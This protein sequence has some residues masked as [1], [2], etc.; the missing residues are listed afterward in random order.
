MSLRKVA[1]KS[2][3]GIAIGLR[4]AAFMLL[5]CFAGSLCAAAQAPPITGIAHLAFRV[6]NLTAERTFFQRLGF[7][8]AFVLPS[9]EKPA[10]VFVKINDRQFIELYPQT[11]DGQPLGWMHV[12]YES[13][14]LN[15]LQ[16]L[17]AAH[18]LQPSPVAKAGAGNLLFSLNDPE[19]RVTEFTQ[20][21]PGS[22]HTLDRGKHLGPNRI[23]TRLLGFSFPSANLAADQHFYTAGLGFEQQKDGSSIRLRLPAAPDL[24]IELHAARP[25]DRIQAI[26]GVSDVQA[27]ARALRRRGFTAQEHKDGVSIEDPN[28]N[29]FVFAADTA[30]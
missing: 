22:R 27:T 21:M 6:Q 25:G 15:A 16:P 18:G 7:E 4:G 19:G 1:K 30:L 11:A 17:Y 12:C 10:E 23:A 24:S 28:G 2:P 8:E 13:D 14:A 9:P 5:A 29:L 20:Y 3:G 26:F